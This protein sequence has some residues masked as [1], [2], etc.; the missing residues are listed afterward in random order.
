MAPLGLGDGAELVLEVPGDDQGVNL[1]FGEGL[2]EAFRRGQKLGAR[3]EDALLVQGL[4]VPHV[5]VAQDKDLLLLEVQ[6]EVQ[7]FE[8]VGEVHGTGHILSD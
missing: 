5:D 4:L 8:I 3:D 2:L 7:E 6:A 1:H